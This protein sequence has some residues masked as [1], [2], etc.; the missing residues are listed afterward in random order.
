MAKILFTNG[1]EVIVSPKNGTDFSLA[2]MQAVVGGYIEVVFLDNGEI[3]VVNEEGKLN[4][5]PYNVAATDYMKANSRYDDFIVGNA[6][7]CK[8]SEVK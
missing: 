1:A 8:R 6:L 3:M 5:L 7:V 2:E 4:G